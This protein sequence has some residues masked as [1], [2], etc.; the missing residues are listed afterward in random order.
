MSSKDVNKTETTTFW[1]DP[2]ELQTLRDEVNMEVEE[3]I[4]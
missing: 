1:A 3:V 4:E 2:E